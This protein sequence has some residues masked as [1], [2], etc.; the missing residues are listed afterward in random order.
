[1]ADI[2]RAYRNYLAHRKAADLLRHLVPIEKTNDP[3][4]IIVKGRRYIN[5]ASNDYLGLSQ[6][7]ALI[8]R[9]QQWAERLGVGA[10]ASRL[11]TGNLA[12]FQPLEEKLAK[13]KDKPA[14]L[15]FPAGFQANATVLHA[16]L[17][18]R[19]HGAKPL[20][21]FDRLNHASM[22]F[23]CWAARITPMRYE[24]CDMA[25]LEALLNG[26]ANQPGPKFILTESIFSMDGDQA[27][28]AAIRR[29]ANQH[30]ATLIVDDAHG[31][32]VCGPR[33]E[34]LSGEA[35]IVIG[36]FSKAMGAQGAFVAASRL[37]CDY[38]IN[39]CTGL[40]Y[41]TALAPPLLGAIDASLDL[42]PKLGKERTRLQHLARWFR[43]ELHA[44]GFETGQAVSAITPVILGEPARVLQAA[45]K[46]RE[47]GLWCTPI[48][49]PTV[50]EGTA[51]LRFTLTAAHHENHVERAIAALK[52]LL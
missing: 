4:Q 42:I 17:D 20:V 25:H 11:V 9:A 32:G 24:H 1:M 35:D 2:E 44:L 40:V 37:V 52:K 28:L 48:R 29:L 23:G 21:F 30:Q 38:L 27:P 47:Q 22:H 46:L 14:A 13:F 16:L 10:G 45:E 5:F 41:S 7:P 12:V 19:V 3:A 39:R 8:A 49:P 18:A 15:V 31:T 6:H 43:A 36:T 50:P 33:G 34:G 51:R 26:H